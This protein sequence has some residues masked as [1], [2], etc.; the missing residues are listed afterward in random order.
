MMVLSILISI[1]KYSQS[2]QNNKFVIPSQYLEKEV[3]DGVHFLHANKYKSF[4][5]FAILFLMEMARH[6]QRTRNKK[7]GI[8]LQYIKKKVLQRFLCSTVMQNIQIFCMGLVMFVCYLFLF[9]M[10]SYGI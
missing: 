7:L 4:C 3:T 8:F 1:V 2:T 9:I 5:N 10:T 6:G